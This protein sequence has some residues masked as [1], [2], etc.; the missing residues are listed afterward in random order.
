MNYRNP[1]E[2]LLYRREDA[3]LLE[4]YHMVVERLLNLRQAGELFDPY[5]M[6]ECFELPDVVAE[7]SE[8][9]KKRV[10]KYKEDIFRLALQ[11]REDILADQSGENEYVVHE[12]DTYFEASMDFPICNHTQHVNGD[13][14]GYVQGIMSNGIPFEAELWLTNGILNLSVIMP[15]IIKSEKTQENILNDGNI[16][17]FHNEASAINGGVLAIGMVDRG[18]IEDLNVIIEYVTLLKEHDIVEF[19]SDME[20]GAVQL[21]TD[22]NGNDFAHIMIMLE[23]DDELLAGTEL[24]FRD[25]PNQKKT[26]PFKV[27]K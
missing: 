15:E 1:E 22:I 7:Y 27:V 26:H 2:E 24:E 11:I 6:M 14:L 10:E 5:S 19:E 8:E 17:G 18:M 21:V 23:Q 3:H 25:F 13:N 12:M 9:Q 16:L 20:N 4:K